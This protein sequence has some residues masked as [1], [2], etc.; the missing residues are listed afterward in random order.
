MKKIIL[1]RHASAVGHVP[2]GG[3]FDRSLRK[4]G[5]KEAK[6]MAAWYAGVAEL[7]SLLVSS[8]AN[9]AIETA[10]IFA[11]EFGYPKKKIIQDEALYGGLDATDFLTILKTL[12]DKHGSVM[13]F[14]HDPSFSEFAQFVAKGFEQYLP[15]C[16]VF[17]VTTNRRSWTT[18]RR[19]DGRLDIFEHP[20]GLRQRQDLA[21]A[22]R[23]EMVDRIENGIV[24]A[25]GEFGVEAE[26]KDLAKIQ[27]VSTKLAKVFA[28]RTMSGRSLFTKKREADRTEDE[29]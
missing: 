13:V 18:I 17:G 19:G 10:Y 23:D 3:D 9:R 6:A 27:R 12:D 26:E 28:A 16:S 5:R 8:P 29:G 11:K 25:I 24:T 1:V 21:E 20:A 22:V 2:D 14:G 4:K 7:P 15:K